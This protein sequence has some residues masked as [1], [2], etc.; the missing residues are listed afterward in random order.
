MCWG[1]GGGRDENRIQRLAQINLRTV[2]LMY[3]I[4]GTF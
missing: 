2:Y 3:D 4:H 1:G